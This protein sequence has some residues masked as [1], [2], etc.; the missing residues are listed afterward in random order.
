[1]S[2]RSPLLAVLPKVR[3]AL[4]GLLLPLLLAVSTAL[5]VAEPPAGDPLVVFLV[6]HA[7]KVDNSHDPK[8]SSTG[9]RRA[10]ELARTLRDSGLQYVH[11]TDFIRTRETAAP[12][13]EALGL[14]VELYE[15][16]QLAAL[17]ERMRRLGGRHLVVGHS[18][19][20][21][22][23]VEL[24]GGDPGDPIEET[25]EYDRLYVVTVGSDGS[26]NTVLLR[27]GEPFEPMP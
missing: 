20:T 4:P 19:S 16:S 6:R 18:N 7:E 25:S 23:V 21:P 24:L 22:D 10:A 13:A 26:V 3:A 5:A 14:K 11:S 12:T 1:M 15:H 27:Y 17:A 8:L 9:R 2:H